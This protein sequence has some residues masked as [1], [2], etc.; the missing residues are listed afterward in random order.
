MTK[1]VQFDPQLICDAFVIAGTMPDRAVMTFEVV[2]G[3][4]AHWPA[5]LR[6]HTYAWPDVRTTPLWNMPVEQLVIFAGKLGRVT[7]F[8]LFVVEPSPI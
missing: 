8:G 3:F 5:L 4:C 7:I 1:N 6:P 2:D